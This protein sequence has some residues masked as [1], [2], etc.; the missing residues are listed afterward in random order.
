M[1]DSKSVA[2][3]SKMM[4]RA[5][6]VVAAALVL[7]ACSKKGPPPPPPVDVSTVA[8]APQAATVAENYVAET[9]AVNTVEI[10]PRVGGVLDP[11]R[12]LL[13]PGLPTRAVIDEGLHRGYCCDA[14]LF[15]HRV[16]CSHD[17]LPSRSVL[18]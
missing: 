16:R 9:E 17:V 12:R 15:N 3:G 2:V 18:G 7:V 14:L 5:L 13:F 1:P 10:R 4:R 6:C 11:G 8:V